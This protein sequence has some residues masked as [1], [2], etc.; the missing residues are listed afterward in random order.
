MIPTWHV[1]V[2]WLSFKFFV[3]EIVW[4]QSGSKLSCGVTFFFLII[5]AH[6]LVTSISQGAWLVMRHLRYWFVTLLNTELQLLQS[7]LGFVATLVCVDVQRV[8][9][10]TAPSCETPTCV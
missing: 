3:C 9:A 4:L 6:A 8:L 2:N 7:V 10:G 1:E 5:I